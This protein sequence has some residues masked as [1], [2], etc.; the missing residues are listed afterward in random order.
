M[1]LEEVT[2]HSWYYRTVAVDLYLNGRNPPIAMWTTIL[3]YHGDGGISRAMFFVRHGASKPRA[4][5]LP[6]IP[7]KTLSGKPTNSHTN[8][9]S[10]MVEKGNA[11][12]ARIWSENHTPSMSGTYL[13]TLMVPSHRVDQT[14]YQEEWNSKQTGC[15]DNVPHPA[16]PTHLSE[17]VG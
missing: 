15:Q 6:R 5:F 8:M 13:C 4:R 7:P 12:R 2:C 3:R 16:P 14:P 1:A 10:R 11:W 9:I 17:H